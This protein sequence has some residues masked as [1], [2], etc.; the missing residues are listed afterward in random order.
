MDPVHA[1]ALLGHVVLRLR[2]ARSINNQGLA[3]AALLFIL[4]PAATNVD[5]LVSLAAVNVV[6][7]TM[8]AYETL[9]YDERRYQLRHGLDVDLPGQPAFVGGRRHDP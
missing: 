7:W 6:R 9:V 5:A 2:N 1:F 4:I 3:L 8:I